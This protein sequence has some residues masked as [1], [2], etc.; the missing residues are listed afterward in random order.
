MGDSLIRPIQV[1]RVG[2]GVVHLGGGYHSRDG[3]SRGGLGA[4]PAGAVGGA[5]NYRIRHMGW[6]TPPQLIIVSDVAGNGVVHRTVVVLMKRLLRIKG[7]G[8]YYP[9]IPA[10]AVAVLRRP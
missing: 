6:L 8:R 3:D 10:Y 5:S 2:C 7:R 1:R 4:L 9:V